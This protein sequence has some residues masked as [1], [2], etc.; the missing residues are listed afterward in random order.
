M[1]RSKKEVFSFRTLIQKIW[2]YIKYKDDDGYYRTYSK[3]SIAWWYIK[4]YTWIIFHFWKMYWFQFTFNWY[5]KCFLNFWRLPALLEAAMD[6]LYASESL[7]KEQIESMQKRY[8]EVKRQYDIPD[9]EDSRH[10]EEVMEDQMMAM[11]GGPDHEERP[12]VI[13]DAKYTLKKYKFKS[14]YFGDWGTDE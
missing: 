10:W 7:S 8:E 13:A 4:H 2:D 11:P 1:L 3:A 5:L 12:G 6:G 9:K 14:K